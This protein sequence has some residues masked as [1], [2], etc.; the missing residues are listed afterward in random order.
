M[1]HYRLHPRT[2]ARHHRRPFRATVNDASPSRTMATNRTRPAQATRCT[3]IARVHARNATRARRRARDRAR[4]NTPKDRP[5]Y[6][7]ARAAIPEHVVAARNM[8]PHRPARTATPRIAEKCQAT[9]DSEQRS[10]SSRGCDDEATHTPGRSPVKTG[11]RSRPTSASSVPDRL[12]SGTTT[13]RPAH[14]LRSARPSH[15]RI[16]PCTPSRPRDRHTR[17]GRE[18][19]WPANAKRGHR[20]RRTPSTEASS[21]PSI[22]DTGGANPIT[23]FL[24]FGSTLSFLW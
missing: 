5:T 24:N 17:G 14:P 19:C 22:Q 15:F 1:C 10:P 21:Q 12:R 2:T 6:N 8:D 3:Q 13:G 11:H 20:G 4:P 7:R 23:N 9:I 18:S 16:S